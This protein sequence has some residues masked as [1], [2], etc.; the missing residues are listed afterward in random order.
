MSLTYADATTWPGLP[1][2]VMRCG[3]SCSGSALNGTWR[4]TDSTSSLTPACTSSRNFFAELLSLI[5]SLSSAWQVD[6]AMCPHTRRGLV[7][8]V[9]ASLAAFWTGRRKQGDAAPRTNRISV[10]TGGLIW[11][12]NF[13]SEGPPMT[14]R[15]P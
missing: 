11:W 12:A 1:E 7:E 4:E 13:M 14:Q 6:L 3:T 9:A 15:L 10:H 2:T 8:A 5:Y